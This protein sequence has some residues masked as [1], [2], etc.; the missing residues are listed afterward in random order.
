MFCDKNFIRDIMYCKGNVRIPN[1]LNKGLHDILV[2]EPVMSLSSF[3]AGKLFHYQLKF[4]R[5]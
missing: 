1:E 4:P 5:K 3:G 2:F